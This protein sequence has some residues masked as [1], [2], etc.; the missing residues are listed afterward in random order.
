MF[1][2]IMPHEINMTFAHAFNTGD[3][4][5]LMLLYEEK[6]ILRIDGDDTFTGKHAIEIE[7]QKLLTIP[8]K[9]FS[10]N[11]FCIEYGDIA[12][13]RADYYI[14]DSNGTTVL[15]GSSAEVVRQQADGSW[16]YII[17]HAMGATLRFCCHLKVQN[18]GRMDLA[19]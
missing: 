12:L 16:L 15:S 13:L 17:D 14:V 11:N 3:I 1:K 8:G 19:H 5:N 4:N 6:A 7:L 18:M 9:M 10:N 2:V